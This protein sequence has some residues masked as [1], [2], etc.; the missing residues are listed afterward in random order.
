MQNIRGILRFFG[1]LAARLSASEILSLRSVETPVCLR[2]NPIPNLESRSSKIGK[3]LQSLASTLGGRNRPPNRVRGALGS[4]VRSRIAS[5][6]PTKPSAETIHIPNATLTKA[7]TAQRYEISGWEREPSVINALFHSAFC[8]GTNRRQ[9]GLLVGM[10]ANLRRL[11][12]RR[13]GLL[14]CPV[15]PVVR[16]KS[17]RVPTPVMLSAGSE[18]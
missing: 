3:L 7:R 12:E 18:S 4:R 8:L 14:P 6:I 5:A 10:L 13:C 17:Y 15:V 1:C 11:A 16:R 2:L 9:F